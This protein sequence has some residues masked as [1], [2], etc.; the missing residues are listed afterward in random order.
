MLT[1]GTHLLTAERERERDQAQVLKTGR[2]Q[3]ATVG[4]M[5]SFPAC[6][7]VMFIR[8]SFLVIEISLL[9]TLKQLVV[10]IIH[11]GNIHMM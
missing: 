6:L 2:F 7:W 4:E 8:V 11:D 10:I 3:P 5:S 9:G 1:E